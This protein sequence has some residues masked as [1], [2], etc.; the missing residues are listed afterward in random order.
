M[1]GISVWGPHTWTML[2]TLAEKIN[3]TDYPRL[4]AQL[5][6]MV[7][8]ICAVLPC[9]ECSEHA[10]TFLNTIKQSNISNKEDFINML[11]LFHNRVN[12]RKKKPLFNHLNLNKYK[13]ISLP[14]AYSNFISVFHTRGNM[15]MLAET[16]QR[17]LVIR[18]LR[19]WLNTNRLSF[20]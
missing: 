18:D 9:P 14:Q 10:T 20:S 5:F 19:T 13:S 12:V 1:P 8:R 16:F 11:Y 7:K 3:E 4:S 6:G 17:Q 15:K 2:H